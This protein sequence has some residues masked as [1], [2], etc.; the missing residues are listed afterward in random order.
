[1]S[2]TGKAIVST[3]VVGLALFSI[4]T[5]SAGK[6]VLTD[7]ELETLL[8]GNTMQISAK[9]DKW[10]QYLSEGGLLIG[11]WQGEKDQ[12]TYRTAGEGL[13]CRTWKKWSKGEACWQ[14][15]QKKENKFT[16]KLVSGDSSTKKS[17]LKILEGDPEN[18]DPN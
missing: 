15:T 6:K 8:V 1:M 7:E 16:T 11:L 14:I 3:C 13:F 12:G 2:K 4:G 5:A 9:G 10:H 18:L 17:K